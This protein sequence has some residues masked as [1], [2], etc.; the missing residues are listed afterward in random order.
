MN[1]FDALSSIMDRLLGPEGCPWDQEQTLVSLRSSLLEEMYEVLEAIDLNQT[2]LMKEEFGDLFFNILFLCKVAEKYHYF[3]VSEVL[4]TLA[5]KLIR[6]H[7][8]VF[9]EVKLENT[10]EVIEQWAAIKQTEKE[11]SSHSSIFDNIPKDLPSLAYASKLIKRVQ[12]SSI[13]ITQL[14]EKQ[15]DSAEQKIGHALWSIVQQAVKEKVDPEQALRATIAQFKQE[16]KTKAD[17]N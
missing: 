6:R 1:A 12:K 16:F 8:H 3:T 7:P 11:K 4:N 2:D 14:Q 13:P 15:S 17:P 5:D 10:E 9:G